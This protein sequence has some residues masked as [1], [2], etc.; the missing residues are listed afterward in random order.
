MITRR[1]AHAI[2]RMIERA[3]VSLTDEDALTAIELYPQWQADTAYAV[4]ER[5]RYDGKLYRVI[6]SHTSQA[7]WI[8]SEVP[9]LYRE[10]SIEEIPDWVQPMGAEDAYHIGDKVRH[11]EK[12][13]VSVV[14][15]NVWEPS[16]YGWDEV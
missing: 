16:V 5:I 2:R 13:W 9:A 7:D 12:V 11:V 1:H 10:V 8:P 3:S 15:N 4:D 6:Q 14:D